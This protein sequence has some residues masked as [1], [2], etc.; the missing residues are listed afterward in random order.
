MKRFKLKSGGFTVVEFLLVLIILI[1][2]GAV[3]YFVARHVD[4]NQNSTA[5]S[6][7]AGPYSGWKSYSDSYISMKYP[8]SWWAGTSA[9]VI[10]GG[11]E[12]APKQ[13][14]TQTFY[15]TPQA[16]NGG[17]VNFELTLY[18]DTDLNNVIGS[19]SAVTTDCA[20]MTCDILA[21]YPLNIKN[22]T[23]AK[24]I[25]FNVTNNTVPSN[26][27]FTNIAAVD[28]PTVKV[29]PTSGYITVKGKIMVIDGKPIYQEGNS[30]ASDIASAS[31]NNLAQFE[32]S[33]DFQ[34]SIKILNSLVVK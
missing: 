11:V 7:T 10:D 24:L 1:L 12:V 15:N 19:D 17:K 26:Q 23:N 34:N 25:I 4:N 27:V 5:Q 31:V 32:K 28:G 33:S 21:V 29:G 14:T 6:M 16:T 20:T 2:I 8:S 18:E 9:S 3:G 13:S 22:D 30:V